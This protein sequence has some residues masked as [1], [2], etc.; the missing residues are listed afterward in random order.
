MDHLADKK[1]HARLWM[2]PVAGPTASLNSTWEL[3]S[4][5]NG[6]LLSEV[7]MEPE[8]AAVAIPCFD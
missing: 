3:T 8:E 1:A 5:E 6:S 7:F 4:G 2:D